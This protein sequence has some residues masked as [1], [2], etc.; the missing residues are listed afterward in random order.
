MKSQLRYGLL[1]IRLTGSTDIINKGFDVDLNFPVVEL[2]MDAH[3]AY[4]IGCR[5]IYSI[6]RDED[7]KNI[8]VTRDCT[9]KAWRE[10]KKRI[11]NLAVGL[12]TP[13]NASYGESMINDFCKKVFTE[14]LK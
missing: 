13:I 9:E 11:I 2:K 4:D 1:T 6:T 14:D 5:L 3:E 8:A 12:M 10:N 7:A